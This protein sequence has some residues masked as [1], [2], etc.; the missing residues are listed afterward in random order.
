MNAIILSG[1]RLAID[2]I[3]AVAT[4]GAHVEISEDARLRMTDTRAVV[5]AIVSE[6]LP[7]YG[8]STG[9]GRLCDVTIP[10][11]KLDQLQENLILSHCCGVG[12]PLGDAETRAMMVLRANVLAMGYSGARPEIAK[13]ICD[14][15]N[16]GITP[17]VPSRG[18]VGASGD[19]APL[20]HVALCLLGEGRCRV[21][22]KSTKSSVALKKAGLKPI[23]LK[24]KEGLSLINGTQ[25][26]TAVAALAVGRAERLIQLADAIAATSVEALAGVHAAFDSR[27]HRVRP[28]FG[29]LASAAQVRS[30]LD[31]SEILPWRRERNFRVQDAYSLRCIPQVHGAVRG[32]IDHVKSV[33]ETETGSATDNPLIF[34]NGAV[35]SGGNFHGAPVA[36]ALDYAAIA[37]TDL[38][39]ISERRTDRLLNPDTNEGLPAFLAPEPGLSS[40]MMIAHVASVALLNEMKVLSSPA[41]IDNLPT[42][43]GTEDHVSMGMTSALKLAKIVENAES[44]LAIE[45][46]AAAEGLEYRKPL[47]PGFGVI[48][49]HRH[50]R[51]LVKPL[52]RDRVLS[53]DIRALTED[54]ASGKMLESIQP[55]IVLKDE[56]GAED[57][58]SVA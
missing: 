52:V 56:A 24:A 35:L 28:H 54:I 12:E 44:C 3:E 11:S 51:E 26:L 31:G 25:A 55:F 23:K 53:W 46:L 17:E 47:K 33:V 32:V 9:F 38:A 37:L 7:V 13:S 8:I 19:L 2:Q 27:I 30:M 5:D 36:M 4:G 10:I 42:S 20:A 21:A 58:W 1:D 49:L 41:S 14:L 29:Q 40:G 45:L 22:G 18:S 16:Y 39:G 34:P 15:L 43:G 57:A 50:V 6:G 48:V